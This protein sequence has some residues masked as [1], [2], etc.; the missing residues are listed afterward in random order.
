MSE[1]GLFFFFFFFFLIRALTFF[2]LFSKVVFGMLSGSQCHNL[3]LLHLSS[4]QRQIP[5]DAQGA[6]C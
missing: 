2:K 3:T 1:V 6:G 5:R 4:G